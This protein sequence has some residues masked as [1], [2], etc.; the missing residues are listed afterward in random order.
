MK[1]D[2]IKTYIMGMRALNDAAQNKDEYQ[3]SNNEIDLYDDM[4]SL[5]TLI[6]NMIIL[7]YGADMVPTLQDI[8]PND[9]KS[10]SR[11]DL[12]TQS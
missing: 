12:V 8:F 5:L 3:T 9:L 2:L 1:E 6:E 4:V 10:S 11:Q 7:Y